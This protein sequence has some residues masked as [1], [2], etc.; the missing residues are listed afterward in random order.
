MEQVEN[1]VGGFNVAGR[2]AA[3]CP[4][5]LPGTTRLKVLDAE[6]LAVADPVEPGPVLHQLTGLRLHNVSPPLLGGD[7]LA[8]VLRTTSRLETLALGARHTTGRC[9]RER[10]SQWL[11]SLAPSV[12]AGVHLDGAHSSREGFRPL[13]GLAPLVDPVLMNYLSEDDVERGGMAA[14]VGAAIAQS[15]GLPRGDPAIA[16]AGEAHDGP[17]IAGGAG[18]DRSPPIP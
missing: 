5:L 14:P 12:T 4:K 18:A 17:D 7:Q 16:D 3:P 11:G 2:A 9:S 15:P 13:A 1:D 8:A 10:G 6:R